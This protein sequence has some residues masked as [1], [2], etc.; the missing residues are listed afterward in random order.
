MKLS[1]VVYHNVVPP[2]LH[3]ILNCVSLLFIDLRH[4]N[5]RINYLAIWAINKLL[6]IGLER[7]DGDIIADPHR[8]VNNKTDTY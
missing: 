5:R 6:F 4:N 1:L 2:I 7:I 8:N 3:N